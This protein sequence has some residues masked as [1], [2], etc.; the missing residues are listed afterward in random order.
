MC[1]WH[2][3]VGCFDSYHVVGVSGGMCHMLDSAV[4]CLACV[5]CGFKCLWVGTFVG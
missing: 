5:D 2:M 4:D 3:F 1:W